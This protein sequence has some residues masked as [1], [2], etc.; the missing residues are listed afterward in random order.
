MEGLGGPGGMGG[1]GVEPLDQSTG[2]VWPGCKLSVDICETK[3]PGGCC[4][5]GGNPSCESDTRGLTLGDEAGEKG[6]GYRKVG[7]WLS[8]DRASDIE[9]GERA[10]PTGDG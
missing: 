8:P 2:I 1:S 6:E 3:L 9:V 4:I 10:S 5:G 7:A